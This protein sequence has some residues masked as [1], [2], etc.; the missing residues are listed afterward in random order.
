MV[1]GGAS[2]TMMPPNGS[3]RVSGGG[4]DAGSGGAASAVALAER[5][6]CQVAV[7]AADEGAAEPGSRPQA[8]G[9]PSLP[10]D[11]RRRRRVDRTL[12]EA[13]AVLGGPQADPQLA[14]GPAADVRAGRPGR[15]LRRR[16]LE[17]ER[18]P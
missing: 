14:E 12:S 9:R 7:A 17:A 3:A 16:E 1:G 11:E 13:G 4:A 2:P 15:R 18:T 10:T 8:H 6:P 5:V